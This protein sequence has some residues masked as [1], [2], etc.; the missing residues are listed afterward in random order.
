VQLSDLTKIQNVLVIEPMPTDLAALDLD[1]E[2][3]QIAYWRQFERVRASLYG[4]ITRRVAQ[5]FESDRHLLRE[6]VLRGSGIPEGAPT[7]AITVVYNLS[8]IWGERIRSIYREVVPE[9]ARRVDAGLMRLREEKGLPSWIP[10]DTPK[11]DFWL[12][13]ADHW[14]ATE[15]GRKIKGITETTRKQ[16]ADYLR[17]GLHKGDGIPELARRVD[18]LYLEQIIPH[19]SVVI[20]RTEVICAS[21]L[22]SRIGAESTG[23]PLDKHWMATWDKRTRDAHALA[24]GQVRRFDEPYHVNGEPLNFPGDS[25]LGASAGNTIMCRC[26]EGYQKAEKEWRNVEDIPITSAPFV[27][28]KWMT[29][30][31]NLPDQAMNPWGEHQISQAAKDRR[32]ELMAKLR[33]EGR[34]QGTQ[35]EWEWVLGKRRMAAIDELYRHAEQANDELWAFLEHAARRTGGRM[36]MTRTPADVATELNRGG[37]VFMQ[38]PIKK[39]AGRATEKVATKYHGDARRLTDVVRASVGVDDYSELQGIVTGLERAGM[40]LAEKAYDRFDKVMESGYRDF[41]LKIEM[42]G[43]M[44]AELQIHVNP[45]WRYKLQAARRGARPLRSA[46]DDNGRGQSD[47]APADTRRAAEGEPPAAGAA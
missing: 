3:K 18:K 32:R 34:E 27:P 29:D 16:V 9:F 23:I 26:T 14:L 47:R 40:K 1:T 41:I 31:R 43:G 42:P 22:G 6:Q 20:A 13:R 46:T 45:V 5:W 21:N 25:S 24:N 7:A 2:E 36:A 12:M 19:R 15:G 37:L 10:P 30:M 28:V 8:S 39:K 35:A 38:G 17:E 33:R 11:L 44:K 4:R